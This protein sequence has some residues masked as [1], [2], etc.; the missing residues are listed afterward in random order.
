MAGT[1]CGQDGRGSF[2]CVAAP[3]AGAPDSTQ[4][5]TFAVTLVGAAIAEHKPNGEAWDGTSES[6]CLA[7]LGCASPDVYAAEGSRVAGLTV[8][9][10]VETNTT[11][12]R[13]N[14]SLGTADERALVGAAI[15]LTLKD[16]DTA[17]LGDDSIGSCSTTVT[18]Q[19][20]ADGRVTLTGTSG[21]SGAIQSVEIGLAR[22]D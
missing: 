18:A 22:V 9:R 14:L 19:H 11:S 4:G 1:R 5:G 20:V 10:V 7:F 12:P 15:T 17:V 8:P 2:R 21:C 16:E 6:G 13:W 3:D